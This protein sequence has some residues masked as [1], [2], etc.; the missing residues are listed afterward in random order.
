[1]SARR[2][3]A[4]P[5]LTATNRLPQATRHAWA[6]AVFRRPRSIHFLFGFKDRGRFGPTCKIVMLHSALNLL[7]LND[8]C[9]FRPDKMTGIVPRDPRGDQ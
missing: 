7:A 8:S 1:M 5:A 6:G 2:L 4:E 9:S 3:Q